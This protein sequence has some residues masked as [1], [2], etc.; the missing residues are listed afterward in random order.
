MKV[1]IFMLHFL[2]VWITCYCKSLYSVCSITWVFLKTSKIKKSNQQCLLMLVVLGLVFC[3]FITQ[4]CSNV[5]SFE[6]SL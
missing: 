6:G 2:P 4:F 1:S 5:Y 3:F